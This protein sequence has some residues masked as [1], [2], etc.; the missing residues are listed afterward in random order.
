MPTRGNRLDGVEPRLLRQ[1]G[2]YGK[3]F[4]KVGLDDWVMA[5]SNALLMMF[6]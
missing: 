4:E 1:S 3:A 5:E 2:V 6:S